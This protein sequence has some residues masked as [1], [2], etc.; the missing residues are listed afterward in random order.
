MFTKP[1]APVKT[2]S[3]VIRSHDPSPGVAS[4]GEAGPSPRSVK[5]RITPVWPTRAGCHGLTALN[6]HRDHRI[7]ADD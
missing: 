7:F 2:A 1:A 4:P 3:A 6:I 5:V